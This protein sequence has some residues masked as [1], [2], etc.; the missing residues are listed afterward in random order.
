M[1]FSHRKCFAFQKVSEKPC[2]CYQIKP[3][4]GENSWLSVTPENLANAKYESSIL[5]KD[6]LSG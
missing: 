2:A 6:F 1:T 3:G 5:K 4:G